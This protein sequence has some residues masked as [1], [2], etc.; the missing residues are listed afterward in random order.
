MS[1][2]NRRLSLVTACWRLGIL[3]AIV[4]TFAAEAFAQQG[5]TIRGRVADATGG[6]L[7]GVTVTAASPALLVPQTAV[8]DAE[9]GYMLPDLPVGR[10][11]ITYELTG[12]QRLVREDIQLTLGFSAELNIVL[13]I[14]GLEES[15]TVSGESP[16]VDTSSTTQ[17]VHLSGQ[18]IT[19][20][21]PA[22]HT[23]NSFVAVAP[24]VVPSGK[25]DLGGGTLSSGGSSAYGIS[26][27]ITNMI[28]GV[29]T[30]QGTSAGG[31]GP[32]MSSIEEMQVTAVAGGAEQALPGIS[33][34]LI[35]KSG[36][37]EFHG[38]TH[39]QGTTDDVQSDNKPDQLREQGVTVGDA[40]LSNFELTGDLGGRLI[41]DKFWFYTAHRMERANT[42]LLGYSKDAGADRR[43][44]TADDIAG[45]MWQRFSNQTL[46]LTYQA[47]K[48]YKLTGLHTRYQAQRSP[49]NGS[50]TTPFE[51]S[52]FNYFYPSQ[53]K[54]ELQGTP[55]NRFVFRAFLGYHEYIAGIIAQEG[56]DHLPS[57][58]DNVTL[59]NTGPFTG[60]YRR[61]RVSWQPDITASY[62]PSGA[63]ADH[64]F[65]AGYTLY[66]QLSGTQYLDGNHGNYLLIF[67]T[68][69]GVPQQAFQIETYNNPVTPI[70][71]NNESGFYVQDT[72]RAT[73]R[74]TVNL[75]M[76]VD[77]F[78]TFVPAQARPPGQ[79]STGASFPRVE[80]GTWV[81][82]AP[83][84]GVVY[85]L[86]GDGKTVVKAH[87]GIYNHAPGDDFA[88]AYNGNT[89]VTTT[90][91]WRDLNGNRDYDPGEVN[92]STVGPDFLNISG[93]ANNI[94]N[95]DL[96]DPHTTEVSLIL[97]RQLMA[98]FGARVSYIN[99]R[100]DDLYETVN[101]L[102]PYSAWNIPISRVDPGPDGVLGNTDDGSVVTVWDYDP[103]FRGSNFVGDM[104]VN[105]PSDRDPKRHTF[106]TVL[107]KRATGKWGLL[108]SLTVQKIDRPIIG[109]PQSP[110]ED[111]NN[112]D[113]TWEWNYKANGNYDLPWGT[114][115]SGSLQVYNGIKRQR[116]YLFRNIPNAG[117]VTLRMDDFGEQ[118]APA[119]TL[120][121]L[122]VAKNMILGS[123]HRVG[124]SMN[125]LNA[126]NSNSI[127]NISNASGPTY[128]Q[129]SSFTSPRIVHGGLT[130]SF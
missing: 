19:E 16:V 57:A 79:F 18:A 46:K 39:V 90:Y 17:S 89:R 94:L 95:P 86:R 82:P 55:S 75:G 26:G 115:L 91:R 112:V 15:V 84:L 36:G 65:K 103:A 100:Q 125:V 66:R 27:Q 40:I 59:I 85:D 73:S 4:L 116:T 113:N 52:G 61:P 114:S 70:D 22:V 9:G 13:R 122:R 77:R 38:R 10:Y 62:F 43:Y 14:G 60:N 64:E 1:L 83:R 53:T 41:R 20:V 88:S 92:L 69:G 31:N 126:L 119:R 124:L 127:W 118:A 72:W 68:V 37:N 81:E 78:E 48:N 120:L 99:I 80:T 21:I 23:L 117:T 32:D 101:V 54:L 97:E 5:A 47:A 28:D 93:S 33:V 107:T 25:P 106:E 34:N 63:L 30:R 2:A 56:F 8:T 24:G 128:G 74:L 76:R 105:R 123:G 104:R 11:R 7:P 42:T 35:V 12:F 58:R 102:R 71:R 67:D 45:T 129:I 87:F 109:V 49:S 108:G 96:R 130:Y 98:N 29:N 110:N 3:V 50:R 6:T 111:F 51:A 121:N 44:G